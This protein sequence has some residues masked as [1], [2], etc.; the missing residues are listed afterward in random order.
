MLT[1]QL[2]SFV[3]PGTEAIR[4]HDN[5]E[6]DAL[7][8]ASQADAVT[9]GSHIFFRQGR[10]RPQ[11]DEGF[12]LLT[13]EALHVVRAMQPGIA[14]RRATQAG[15]Q[16]EEQAASTI[17][18]RALHARRDVTGRARAP[19]TSLQVKSAPVKPFI[20]QHMAHQA[21]NASTPAQQPMRASIDRAL[22]NGERAQS[23]SSVMPN[24]DE[25]KRTL[26]RDLIR[27]IKADLERGG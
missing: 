10:F 16:E 6:S 4:I 5:I 12:A 24:M 27:Q 17:E 11:E 7:A 22:E 9:L 21:V 15:I 19:S 1:Q 3:G 23:M 14:W 13:H 26:Y 2:Q 25:L 18:S 20:P 8:Q